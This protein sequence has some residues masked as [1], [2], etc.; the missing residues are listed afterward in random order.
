M[1]GI[2][3][4]HA[5]VIVAMHFGHE[6]HDNFRLYYGATGL[7]LEYIIYLGQTH[8]QKVYIAY[9]LNTCVYM[10]FFICVHLFDCHVMTYC[11]FIPLHLSVGILFWSLVIN[12]SN[13][14]SVENRIPLKPVLGD[15]RDVALFVISNEQIQ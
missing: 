1:N 8:F 13:T 5:D 7:L 14:F 12:G 4:R 3:I 10:Y 9:E 11:L 2:V 6:H 15:V